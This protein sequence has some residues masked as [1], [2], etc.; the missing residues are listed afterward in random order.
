MT[1]KS[2]LDK[3]LQLQFS[4]KK[5]KSNITHFFRVLNTHIT[6]GVNLQLARNLSNEQVA[7]E[8]AKKKLS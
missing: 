4:I 5:K 8:L 2:E 7:A 1:K 3:I 6:V